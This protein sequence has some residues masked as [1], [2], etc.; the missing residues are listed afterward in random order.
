MQVFT[1]YMLL[2]IETQGRQHVKPDF[3]VASRVS[4]PVDL[5]QNQL[6]SGV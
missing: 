2:K 4:D 5:G 3:R 6:V 1:R